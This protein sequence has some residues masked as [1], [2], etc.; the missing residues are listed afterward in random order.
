M[1]IQEGIVSPLAPLNDIAAMKAVAI[2]QRGSV[3]DFIDLFFILQK[4]NTDFNQLAKLVTDKYDLNQ[5]YD[6]QLK[7]S[8]VYFDDAEG[9]IEQIT[10]LKNNEPV[11]MTPAEWETIKAFYQEFAT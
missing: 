7:T 8:F 10:M 6:Y 9:E 1:P 11:K 2:N 4:T 3:K 5:G